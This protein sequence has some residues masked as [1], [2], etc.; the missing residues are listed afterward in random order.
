MLLAYTATRQGLLQLAGLQAPQDFEPEATPPKKR[1]RSGAEE[2]QKKQKKQKTQHEV[3]EKERARLVREL[4][5]GGPENLVDAVLESVLSSGERKAAVETDS[6]LERDTETE[7]LEEGERRGGLTVEE[8]G[9]V[10]EALEGRAPYL[11]SM[12][13]S[14][15]IQRLAARASWKGPV[16]PGVNGLPYVNGLAGANGPSGVNGGLGWQHRL[17]EFALRVLGRGDGLG[18]FS[19]PLLKALLRRCLDMGDTRLGGELV[20]ALMTSLAQSKAGVVDREGGQRREGNGEG[21]PAKMQALLRLATVTRNASD[22]S[23]DGSG[24]DLSD[25]EFAQCLIAFCRS[26]QV[27]SKPV[28]FPCW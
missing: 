1:K 28:R 11:P 6:R 23:A 27:V 22:G 15:T 13:L 20:T 24:V 5:E 16:E 12:L 7:G 26:T 18:G 21:L 9:G 2:K 17:K 4:V 14:E 3:L 25:G 10:I 8:L 19:A